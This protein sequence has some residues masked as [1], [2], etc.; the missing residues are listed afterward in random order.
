MGSM[1]FGP[2]CEMFVRR[3]ESVAESQP[4]RSVEKLRSA[5]ECKRS[6]ARAGARGGGARGVDR[7]RAY[8]CTF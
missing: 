5:H 1:T 2:I 3:A 7:Y 4:P 6:A 8:A